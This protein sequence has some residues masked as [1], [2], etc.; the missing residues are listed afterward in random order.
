MSYRTTPSITEQP[1]A[2]FQPDALLP[3]QYFETY[4]SSARLGPEKKLMLAVLE[5]VF[6]CFQKY[7]RAQNRRGKRLMSEAEAGIRDENSDWFFSF[8]NICAALEFNPD[9]LRHGLAQAKARLVMQSINGESGGTH[10][11]TK[12]GYKKKKYRLAA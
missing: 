1:G 12:K 11:P 8:E 7:A 9:Y 10:T 6:V 5:D 4:Q 3:A 2:F